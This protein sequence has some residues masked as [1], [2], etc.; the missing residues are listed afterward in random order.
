MSGF[1]GNPAYVGQ[2]IGQGIARLADALFNNDYDNPMMIA[3]AEQIAAARNRDAKLAQQ[4]EAEQAARDSYAKLF[5]QVP[6]TWQ[7]GR[8]SADWLSQAAAMA[9]RAGVKPSDFANMTRA[10][11][12]MLGGDEDASFRAAVGAG[13]NP[14]TE[15][16]YTPQ[17]QAARRS[18]LAGNATALEQLKQAGDLAAV[19]AR[20][21]QDRIT[22]QQ[23]P[24]SVDQVIAGLVSGLGQRGLLSSD[25]VLAGAGM[26]GKP[27]MDIVQTPDGGYA[28]VDKNNPNAPV[29]PFV[30]RGPGGD[31]APM[32]VAPPQS[33]N[34]AA[35]AASRTAA[36]TAARLGINAGDLHFLGQV[37]EALRATGGL[38]SSLPP[39]V[40][41]RYNA[42]MAR[43]GGGGDRVV[44]SPP[45][46]SVPVR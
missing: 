43:I 10:L 2:P 12:P 34:D 21:A 46:G 24:R 42:I 29:L 3:R 16:S 36:E 23:A 26:L 37:N 35:T 30:G 5:E 40:M 17:A 28:R 31:L 19:Q 18:Q 33:A 20:G 9:S 14:T 7:G 45:P 41:N 27:D 22:Q 4:A 25:N 8:P 13:A 6:T 11:V 38:T 15:T 44:A 1:V 39:E 32:P